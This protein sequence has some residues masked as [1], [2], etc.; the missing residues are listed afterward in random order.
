MWSDN[1]TDRDFLNFRCVADTAAELIIQANGRPLSMGVSGGWGVGKSSMLKFI[2]VALREREDGRYLFVEFNAWLYQGYDDARASLM[3]VIA[4]HLVEHSET[5]S[6]GM[7]H[8]KEFL[9]RVNWLRTAGL[10]AGSALAM[11]LGLPPVG[12]PGAVRTMWKGLTDGDVTTEDVNAAVDVGGKAAAEGAR[13]FKPVQEASPPRL[14]HELRRQ[15]QEALEAMDV[16]LVVFIDDLDRCLPPTTI[17]T[18]E[19]IRLFLFLPRTAFIIAADDRMIRQAVR[20]HFK[21]VE[22]DD[23]LVTNYFDKLVQVPL[24]VP[25]LGTQEVRAYLMLLF[26]ENSGLEAE[27]REELRSAVCQQLAGSWKG[28]RTDHQFVSSLMDDCTDGLRANLALADRLAPLMT[29]AKQIAG[30]PRLIKRFLNTLAIRLSIARAQDVLVDEAALAK[31]LLFE[32]C[33]DRKAHL[34]LLAAINDG[35]DG[36]PAF[37]RQWEELAQAGEDLKELPP[38]WNNDFVKD[39]L[40]LPPSLADVDLRGVVYVSREHLPVITAADQ[41][42]SDAAQLLEAL[43]ALDQRAS[44]ALAERLKSLSG[45]E[46]AMIAERLLVRARQIP[47]WGTPPVL[48]AYM[49]LIQA[50]ADLAGDLSRFLEALPGARLEPDIVPALGDHEWARRA[51]EKWRGDKEAPDTVRK[52]VAALL[53]AG[54]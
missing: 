36:K 26:I 13:L 51:L 21:G 47:R 45:R 6:T 30:N 22:L 19:A 46:L 41:L 32:R 25:P 11:S 49:T 9:G 7:A 48:W 14:I 10:M 28:M 42:S 15:F 37:L 50:D 5:N 24:R 44:E 17:S 39:W 53:R 1:E 43:L 33:G 12:L 40:A 34:E 2:S 3:E 27:R 18:L 52:A 20:V 8:A 35:V 29:S 23:D 54:T 4:E 38:Q 16:T 31:M